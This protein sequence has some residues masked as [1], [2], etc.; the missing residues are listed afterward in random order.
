M[1][2]LGGGVWDPKDVHQKWHKNVS[3]SKIQFFHSKKFGEVRGGG[4]GG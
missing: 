1:H 3:I 4:G 2:P